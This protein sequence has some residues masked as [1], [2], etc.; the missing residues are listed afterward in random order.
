MLDESRNIPVGFHFK[1]D[2]NI[3]HEF[4]PEFRFQEVSG[5]SVSLSTQEVSEGGENRFKLQFPQKPK[6][7][8]L[9]LKRG[10]LI[11]SEIVDWCKDAIEDYDFKRANVSIHLLNG[12]HD[13]VIS[14]QVIDAYPVKWE[15]SAFNAEKSELAIETIELVYKYFSVIGK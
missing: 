4:Y 14:W 8:N 7:S 6:Y 10:L 15:V 1:V 12:K 3:D 9:V 11:G 5:L 2:F 13:A